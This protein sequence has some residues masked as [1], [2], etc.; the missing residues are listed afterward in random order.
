MVAEWRYLDGGGV[1]GTF[2]VDG[3]S[4]VLEGEQQVY[5][6]LED[7]IVHIYYNYNN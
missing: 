2:E 1:T 5:I 6:G 4:V 3:F 7:G